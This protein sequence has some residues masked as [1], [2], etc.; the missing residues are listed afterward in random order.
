MANGKNKKSG[1]MRLI[2]QNNFLAFFMVLILVIAINH[3]VFS[4]L[5]KNREKAGAFTSGFGLNLFSYPAGF[6]GANIPVGTNM[7]LLADMWLPNAWTNDNLTCNYKLGTPCFPLVEA[8]GLATLGAGADDDG[9]AGS[10]FNLVPFG[11]NYFDIFFNW[12]D[13]YCADSC[14][15]PTEFYKDGSGPAPFGDCIPGNSV[16]PDIIF[17]DTSGVIGVLDAGAWTN[18]GVGTNKC[19]WIHSE[20][21]N[22]NNAWDYCDPVATPGCGAT[23]T[24]SIWAPYFTGDTVLAEGSDW[25][26]P[27]LGQWQG[28]SFAAWVGNETFYD[29]DIDGKFGGIGGWAQGTSGDEPVIIDLDGDNIY[30]DSPDTLLDANGSTAGVGTDDDVIADGTVLTPLALGDGVCLNTGGLGGVGQMIIYVDGSGDCRP[31][32]GG[33]DTLIRDDTATGLPAIIA[34][35]GA[36]PYTFMPVVG[37]VSYYDADFSGTWT[38]GAGAAAT[39]SLWAE[40]QGLNQ[41]HPAIEGPIAFEADGT[42]SLVGPGVPPNL[43]DDPLTPGAPLTYLQPADNI[44]FAFPPIGVGLEDI[45]IDGN[46]NCIPGDGGLDTLLMDVTLDGLIPPSTF[47][48]TWASGAGNFAYFDHLPPFGAYTVGPIALFTESLWGEFGSS[49]TYTASADTDV[50]STGLALAGD[51]LIFGAGPSGYNLQYLDTDGSGTLTA[52][53]TVVEDN[54]NIQ[55][56]PVPLPGNNVLDRGPEDYIEM[57][58]IQNIGTALPGSDI[59]NIY[60]CRPGVDAWCGTGDAG[61]ICS[62]AIP[63]QAAES[64]WFEPNMPLSPLS[65]SVSPKLCIFADISPIATAGRTI[66][67]QIPQLVDTGAIPGRYDAGVGEMG[68][69]NYSNNDGPTDAPITLPY[70]FTITALPIYSGGGGVPADTTAPSQAINIQLTADYTGKV[71]LTWTDPVD[72]DLSQIIIKEEYQGQIASSEAVNKGVETLLLT[73]R[74]VSGVYTYY[75]S[76]RDSSGNES[77][78]IEITVTIPSQGEVTAIPSAPPTPILPLPSPE[79]TLPSGIEIGDLLKNATTSTVYVIGNDKK[80]HVFPNEATFF[81]WFKD[82]SQIK[83]VS[84]D[85]L[86]QIVLDSNVTVGP[87]TKLVKIQTDPKVYAVEPGSILRAIKTEAIAREL[88]GYNWAARIL[89]VPD[90]FF[91]DYKV[92]SEISQAIHP[93]ASLIQYQ[94]ATDIYYIENSTKR[95]VVPDVFAYNQYWNEFVL[96][97][98]LTSKV[99]TAGENLPQ[100]S[101]VDQMHLK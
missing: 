11:G 46:G 18:V 99:Y 42:F 50:Y 20:L 34:G 62:A 81:T 78:V 94:G 98:V 65:V 85:I 101:I 45:Y 63:Y 95:L 9:A 37:P 31:G 57:A 96:K 12:G 79:L 74:Q 59:S 66:Q 70:V 17:L 47:G 29:A 51:A 55:T 5:L 43:D 15:A 30:S 27:V 54:G 14:T 24:E 35:F 1:A 3:V 56:G 21:V 36:F 33:L 89:D 52:T 25:A 90:V 10:P 71:I 61:E 73:G 48:G 22:A 44:C 49:L 80:R 88:Y 60:F 68:V 32:N 69:F 26:N 97:N 86:S 28:D 82:F 64:A 7:Q 76:T 4:Y 84:D 41:W 93:T 77:A 83:V 100:M 23:E 72:S 6:T 2:L 53:D 13:Y 75:I 39:E 92:N 19:G 8:D 91:M 38:W 16:A 40:L 67:L 87:G 58:M